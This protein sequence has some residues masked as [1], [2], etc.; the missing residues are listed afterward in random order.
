MLCTADPDHDFEAVFDQ[1]EPFNTHIRDVSK[2]LWSPGS[3]CLW[4]VQ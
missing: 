4:V 1:L 3:I 2:K